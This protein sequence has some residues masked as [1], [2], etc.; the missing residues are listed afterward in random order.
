MRNYLANIEQTLR[1]F[2]LLGLVLYYPGLLF[3]NFVIGYLAVFV[4]KI[5]ML[6][7]VA[8]VQS[9]VVIDGLAALLLGSASLVSAWLLFKKHPLVVPVTFSF[10]LLTLG[11]YLLEP[12]WLR[13]SGLPLE[14]L[15]GRWYENPL[16]LMR[17]LGAGLIFGAYFWLSRHVKVISQ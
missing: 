14:I 16:A 7:N 9:L 13:I 3:Y 6:E 10:L 4:S 2:L 15:N 11:Y 5:E 12:L 1:F 17:P 8:G